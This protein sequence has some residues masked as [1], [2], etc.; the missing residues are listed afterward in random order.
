MLRVEIRDG[1]GAVMISLH[2]RLTG[3]YAEPLRM[4]VNRCSRE[5][6]LLVDLNE[7][8]FV[9]SAGEEVLSFVGE[10]RGE[11]FAENVYAKD[12]C[13]RLQLT[14]AKKRKWRRETETSSSHKPP[15]R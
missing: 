14:R 10:L 5:S 13:N 12:L 1:D 15:A 8:T 6:R 7:V 11:F 9:D 3:E 2:G 4:L